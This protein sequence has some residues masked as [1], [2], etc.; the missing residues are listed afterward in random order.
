MKKTLTL[1]TLVMLQAC[2]NNSGSGGSGGG[3]TSS[4]NEVYEAI[5]ES[6]PEIGSKKFS[7]NSWSKS[8][9][10]TISEWNNT[11]P[12]FMGVSSTS[13]NPKDYVGDLFD[14]TVD[15]SMLERARMPFL[16]SCCM[17]I[18][19]DKTGDLLTEGTQ[20]IT[21]T[22]EVVDVCGT[23]AEVGGM[24]GSTMTVIVTNLA[25]TTKYDQMVYF[26][27]ATNPDMFSNEDQWMYIK[28]NSSVL[29]FMHIG[30]TS[31][32]SDGSEIDVKSIA[33]DKVTGV[34]SFQGITNSSDRIY[35]I[36]LNPVTDDVRAFAFKTNGAGVVSVNLSSTYE[37]QS[38]VALSI[39]YSGLSSPYNASVNDERACI[40][41][42]DASIAQ[43][44]VATCSAN[45]RTVLASSGA[46][47]LETA[48]QAFSGATLKSDAAAG[49][50]DD[51]LPVFDDTSILSAGIQL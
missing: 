9:N 50:L 10:D 11:D 32:G 44:D 42:A 35:R 24:E 34:G 17:D 40:A 37:N 26:D 16:M 6:A 43:N 7:Q 48:V 15:Q 28:N 47:T 14:S 33:Y 18:L 25:D 22:N 39:S 41:T 19:A 45:S 20:V 49:E 21:F 30:D 38:H 13:R 2:G 31:A 5:A 36:Y 12:N 8:I 3:L 27:R 1:A 51:N 4:F 46:D 23:E 29:N